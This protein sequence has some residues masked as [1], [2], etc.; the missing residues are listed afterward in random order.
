MTVTAS[1]LRYEVKFVA[2]SVE[3][4]TVARWVREHPACF[5]TAY[6]P[7]QVNSVYLD[8]HQLSAFAENLAGTSARTKVRFR[9]YGED[10][11]SPSGTLELKCKR[12]RLGWKR[13]FRISTI[14]LAGVS[15]RE[16]LHKLRNQV[17]A[18]ARLA[19]DTHQLVVLVNRY[20]RE[21]WLSA[22]GR[23]RVTI[24]TNQRVFDQRRSSVP[25]L[26]LPTNLPDTLVVEVKGAFAD[27]DL[28][29][30]VIQGVPIRVGRHSKYVVGVESI[31]AA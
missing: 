31:L 25:N 30:R 10:H 4:A 8:D 12:N 3:L 7:R 29:D 21:Y 20:R 11:A 2:P 5:R 28:I 24:D 26:D 23:V 13:N 6:P 17:P 19:L 22:D 15:W 16:V 27:R 9:W 18:E 14:P 1:E